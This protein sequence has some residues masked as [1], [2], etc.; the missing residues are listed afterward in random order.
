MATSSELP[1]HG[2]WFPIISLMTMSRSRR[3]SR[4]QRQRLNR[5]ATTNALHPPTAAFPAATANA[6]NAANRRRC[7]RQSLMTMSRRRPKSRRWIERLNSTP[8]PTHLPSHLIS[9]SRRSSSNSQRCFNSCRRQRR[10]HRHW[11]FTGQTMT[12]AHV[13]LP[14]RGPTMIP[15]MLRLAPSASTAVSHPARLHAVAWA[16]G[17]IDLRGKMIFLRPDTN[18]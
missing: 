15:Y 17:L 16:I 12:M 9:P 13:P 8:P 2:M 1:S 6:A 11:S 10:R 14:K 4:R 5:T 18:A 3:Q 7:C